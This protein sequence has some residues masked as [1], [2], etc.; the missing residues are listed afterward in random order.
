M[1]QTLKISTNQKLTLSAFITDTRKGD[2]TEIIREY[3]QNLLGDINVS[4][5]RSWNK[6]TVY[7][8]QVRPGTKNYKKLINNPIFTNL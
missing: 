7:M 8:L 1:T 2:Q 4:V 3:F 5:S 6:K